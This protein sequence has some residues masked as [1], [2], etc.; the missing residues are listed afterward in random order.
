MSAHTRMDVGSRT[1]RRC[2]LTHHQIL[3]QANHDYYFYF[4]NYTI[5]ERVVSEIALIS[6]T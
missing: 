2:R 1:E 5:L 4:N 6:L 3:A